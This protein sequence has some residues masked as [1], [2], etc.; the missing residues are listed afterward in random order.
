MYIFGRSREANPQRYFEAV[1]AAVE[2]GH[3]AA[4]ISGLQIS[5]FATRYGEPGTTLR[6]STRVE[7]QAELQAAMDKLAGDPA[8]RKWLEAH[9]ELFA[10]APT[11]QLTSIVSAANITPV[12]RRFYTVLTATAANGKYADAIAFGVKGQQFVAE[13]TGLTT[14]FGTSVF[15]AFGSVGWLTGA[16][17]AS[18]LDELRAMEATN[19]GY[20]EL[21]AEAADLFMPGS[22]M[23]SLIEKIG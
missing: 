21:V 8:Y 15:G 3:M 4:N 23:S 19:P 16:D 22:G 11:S 7:S 6:W 13:A 10:G 18:Q 14:M 12:P 5:V 17:D 9:A 1:E 20:H 2:L